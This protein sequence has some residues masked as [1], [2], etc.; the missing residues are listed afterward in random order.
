MRGFIALCIVA[1]FA[2]LGV[3]VGQGLSAEAVAVVVGVVCGVLAGIP[4]AVLMLV[5]MRAQ[6]RSVLSS[7]K[8]RGDEQPAPLRQAPRWTREGPQD[9]A[10]PAH[11]PPVIVVGGTQPVPPAQQNTST[12]DGSWR[13]LE[14]P[15]REFRIIGE[16][17]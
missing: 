17:E 3:V 10:P 13:A 5:A 15:R 11:Y 6:Q 8:G 9:V 7:S 2:G 16:D 14:P 12:V 4:T 1:V